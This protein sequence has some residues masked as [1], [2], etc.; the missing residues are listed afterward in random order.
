MFNN[1]T[2][3]HTLPHAFPHHPPLL[4]LAAL[5]WGSCW[6]GSGAPIHT[7]SSSR[8]TTLTSPPSPSLPMVLL[9]QP[10]RMTARWAWGLGFG[11]LCSARSAQHIYCQLQP[12]AAAILR[13]GTERVYH[14]L[15][16][17]MHFQFGHPNPTQHLTGHSNASFRAL[18]KRTPISS[19]QRV[20]IT[21]LFPQQAKG[22]EAW[23]PLR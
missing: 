1:C 20:C 22:W 18:L 21:K 19:V 11:L 4:Q 2:V 3:A 10:A 15:S 8:A 12:T 23:V 6:C 9:S 13:G 16:F 17:F 5:S 7:C 14:F